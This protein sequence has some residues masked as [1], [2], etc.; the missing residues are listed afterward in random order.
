M[1]YAKF[2]DYKTAGSDEE[3]LKRCLPYL[4]MATILVM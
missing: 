1:F 2:Q 4:G 3:D